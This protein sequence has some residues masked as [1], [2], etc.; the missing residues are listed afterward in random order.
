MLLMRGRLIGMFLL[1]VNFL[2]KENDLFCFLFIADV[3]YT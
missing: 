1:Q 3:L 2:V